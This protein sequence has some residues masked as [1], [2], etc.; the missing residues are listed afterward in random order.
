MARGEGGYNEPS[1][2]VVKFFVLDSP[3][4][5]TE[6]SGQLRLDE[7]IASLASLAFFGQIIF[8][9][10]T[11]KMTYNGITKQSSNAKSMSHSS[12]FRSGAYSSVGRATDF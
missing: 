11:L 4:C 8:W 6:V 1:N 5:G 7:V 12:L 2:G 10:T 3:F 9:T